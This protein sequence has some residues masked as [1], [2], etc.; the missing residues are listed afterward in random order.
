MTYHTICDSDDQ[1]WQ[2]F[3]KCV[4]AAEDATLHDTI[5]IANMEYI[6][7]GELN[8]FVKTKDIL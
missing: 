8:C 1:E 2:D 4:L 6:E 7:S 5:T 3:T